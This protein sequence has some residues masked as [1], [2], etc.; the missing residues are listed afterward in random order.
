MTEKIIGYIL[1]AVGILVIVS[2][3]VAAYQVFTKQATPV[4]VFHFSGI[5][6]DISKALSQGMPEELIKS[7]YTLPPMQQE[8]ISADMINKPI[9]FFTYLFFMGFV[10]SA[11]VKIAG[12]G[13]Q[14]IRP[15]IIKIPEKQLQSKPS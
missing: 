12:L 10:A 7:G 3:T 8:I 2:P 5:S 14:L 11:G 4:E 1:L 15:I 9:N 13:I 6:M